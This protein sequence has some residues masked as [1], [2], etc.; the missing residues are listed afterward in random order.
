M[1]LSKIF[2]LVNSNDLKS[3]KKENKKSEEKSGV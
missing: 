3:E 2:I 1:V